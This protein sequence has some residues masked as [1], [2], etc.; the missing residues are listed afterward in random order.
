MLCSDGLTDVLGP[1]TLHEILTTYAEPD[2]AVGKLIEL[3]N[4]GG[5][6]DNVTVI[7]ADVVPPDESSSSMYRVGVGS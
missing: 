1:E 6:P 5:G 2:A 3:A 7:V 4:E